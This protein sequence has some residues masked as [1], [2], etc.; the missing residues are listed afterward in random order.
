MNNYIKNIRR[1]EFTVT[2][3]CTSRCKHCSLGDD[4]GS[5]KLDKNRAVKLIEELSRVYQIESVMTFGG[6]PLIFPDITCAIHRKAKEC[7]IPLRQIITNG[8]FSKEDAKIRKVAEALADDGVNDILLSVDCFHEEF[9]PVPEIYQFAKALKECYQGKLR[10]HPAWVINREHDNHYNRRTKECLTYFEDLQI[11]VS[12]GN[13]IFPSGNAIKYLS[14]YFD[15]KPIDMSFRC[16]EAPYTAKLD[17]IEEI[18]VNPNG[19]VVACSFLIGN[20]LKQDILEILANYD[21]YQNPYTAALLKGGIS[22]LIAYAKENGIEIDSSNY[23]T[24]CGICHDIARKV[25]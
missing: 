13:D 10:L 17:E 1:V 4:P 7:Q 18:K 20:I 2:H 6:E 16:G 25:K 9:L 11:P 5:D 8:F 19:D 14:D 3:C 23:Y 15:K 21:P 22:E 24:P 12:Y